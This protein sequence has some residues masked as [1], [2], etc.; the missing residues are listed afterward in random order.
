MDTQTYCPNCGQQAVDFIQ[1][2]QA[3]PDHSHSDLLKCHACQTSF[4]LC[5]PND[6]EW[7]EYATERARAEAEEVSEE[8]KQIIIDEWQEEVG[9]KQD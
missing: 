8:A 4:I 6:E 2:F 3:M 5:Y 1:L 9:I 7:A